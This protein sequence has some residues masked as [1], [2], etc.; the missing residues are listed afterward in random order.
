MKLILASKSPRRKEILENLGVSFEIVTAETD[1]SSPITHPAA[2]VEEL[3]RRKAEAVW[4][5]LK[6]EGRELSQILVIASD[7]PTL[8]ISGPS[9]YIEKIAYAEVVIPYSDN[10]KVGD[11]V[12]TSGIR[13]YGSDDKIISTLYM[14]VAND[15]FI[16]K[17]ES[18]NE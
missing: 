17:V 7:T 1:E 13:L 8:E 2:L 9:T 6:R 15:S 12:T 14:T 10:Y 3:S 11:S 4:E 18:I 16:V 5:K